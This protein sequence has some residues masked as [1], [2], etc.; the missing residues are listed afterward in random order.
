MTD[1]KTTPITYAVMDSDFDPARWQQ[2]TDPPQS[3]TKPDGGLWSSPPVSP[4]ENGMDADID[5]IVTSW[6]AWNA[7]ELNRPAKDE[8]VPI[9][10][11]GGAA[12]I[13]INSQDDIDQLAE[14]YPTT[15]PGNQFDCPFPVSFEAMAASGVTGIHVTDNALAV[16]GHTQGALFGWDAASTVWL[17]PE[18]V[19]AHPRVRAATLSGA[20]KT[21]D[22]HA[23]GEFDASDEWTDLSDP[24]P[25][26]R[27]KKAFAAATAE[28]EREAHTLQA[29]ETE[30]DRLR[31]ELDE[32]RGG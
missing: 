3:I 4:E 30:R 14:L 5:G 26:A 32:L 2:I 13:H 10:A 15:T 19:V 24:D 23:D 31:A 9:T 11:A 6:T 22:D 7:I 8:L 12:V 29:L 27:L 17:T 28:R 16:A 18:G 20:D 25:V 21:D 1:A